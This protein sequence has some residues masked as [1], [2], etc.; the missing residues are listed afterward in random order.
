MSVEELNKSGN[1]YRSHHQNQSIR[2][3]EPF[4]TVFLAPAGSG[5][6]GLPTSADSTRARG[7]HL[8][9][10]TVRMSWN[11]QGFGDL[12]VKSAVGVKV[13]WIL[14]FLTTRSWDVLWGQVVGLRSF[15]PEC[16]VRQNQA[17]EEKTWEQGTRQSLATSVGSET[18]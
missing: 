11:G 1:V 18:S 10:V 7:Q 4:L 13:T 2:E 15:V 9:A 6:G 8:M 16:P 14:Y 17:T 5:R 12:L 3:R